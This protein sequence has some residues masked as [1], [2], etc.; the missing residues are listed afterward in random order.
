MLPVTSKMLSAGR[1]RASVLPVCVMF[2]FAAL[3][4]PL[5]SATNTPSTTVLT[6]SPASPQVGG[7]VQTLTATV[8][9]TTGGAS[10][11]PGVVNFY[12]L[13][14]VAAAGPGGGYTARP[15]LIGTAQLLSGGTASI[16][17]ILGG[18]ATHNLHA[19]FLP[20][21]SYATSS[22]TV[23]G[24]VI[25]KNAI[26]PFSVTLTEAANA[27]SLRPSYYMRPQYLYHGLVAPGGAFNYVNTA[28]NAPVTSSNMTLG[29]GGIASSVTIKSSTPVAA[30]PRSVAT[31]DFNGDGKLD[32]VVTNASAATVSVFLGNG[33]GTFGSENTFAVLS[34]GVQSSNGAFSGVATGDFNNDGKVD[35]AVSDGGSGKISILLN[36]SSG[37]TL[38]FASHVD[39]TV[40]A[41][42]TRIV[43]ADFNHDGNLDLAV[44]CN[45]TI[46][47]LL[48]SGSGTF[49]AGTSLSTAGSSDMLVADLN[50]DGAAD[51]MTSN[52]GGNGFDMFLGNGDGTFQGVLRGTPKGA[53][54]PPFGIAVAD[55]NGDGIP[56][57]VYTT[58]GNGHYNMVYYVSGDGTGNFTTSN[59]NISVTYVGGAPGIGGSKQSIA[60]GDVNGDGWPDVVAGETQF[61]EV[62]VLY[63]IPGQAGATSI[64]LNG[65][66]AI[67]ATT[68]NPT[69]FVA[70]DFRGDGLS[71]FAGADSNGNV[72]LFEYNAV[73]QTYVGNT[74]SSQTPGI[75]LTSSSSL[76]A[77][78]F[79]STYV[80][81][82]PDLYAGLLSNTVNIPVYGNSTPALTVANSSY[83]YGQS[84]SLTATLPSI[85]STFP[86][87]TVDINNSGNNTNMGLPQGTL[88]ASG[89]ATVSG[90][91]NS[92]SYSAVAS[93]SGDNTFI[94]DYS[95]TVTFTVVPET[96]TM[97][98]SASPTSQIAG[99]NVTVTGTLGT[100][101]N[102][103][104]G[105]VLMIA[106]GSNS[107]TC[108][109]N[110][111]GVCSVT[112]AMPGAGSQTAMATVA[113]TQNMTT[114]SAT[115]TTTGTTLTSVPS[116]TSSA[117]PSGNGYS[118]TYTASVATQSGVA[119]SGTI[120]FETGSGSVLGG[121]TALSSGVAM[122]TTTP[123]LGNTTVKA[124]YSGNIAY[125]PTTSSTL[126]Q[127]VSVFTS[128]PALTSSA[129]PAFPTQ[130]ITFTATLPVVN[131]FTPT[132]SV[133]FDDGSNTL[134]TFYLNGPSVA[135]F[136]TNALA[137]G[138]HSIVAVYSGDSAFTPQSSS[139]LT[140]VVAA[141][142][143]VASLSA[144]ATV[145]QG[146]PTTLSATVTANGNGVNP[147]LVQFY[148]A[149]SSP[150]LLGTASTNSSGV[151]TLVRVLSPG[152]HVIH[153]VFTGQAAG[154]TGVTSGT[155]TATVTGNG[156]LATM[157]GLNLL[158]VPGGYTLSAPVSLSG[159]STPTG[160]VNFLDATN[161]SAVIG[162]GSVGSFVRTVAPPSLYPLGINPPGI[163]SIASATGD[164]NGDGILD[165]VI[166]NYT[167]GGGGGASSISVLL[168]VG[169][170]TFTTNNTFQAF[171][172]TSLTLVDVDQD[173]I[174]DLLVTR[175]GNN[176]MEVYHGVGDGTFTQLNDVN[177]GTFPIGV[178]V[179]DFDKDGLP[180]LVI[181]NNS[182]GVRYVHGNGDGTFG[183]Y[184]NGTNFTTGN[185]SIGIT[186]GDY[187]R[188]GNPDFIITNAADGTVGVFLGD[189]TG[190]FAP[191][192]TYAVGN[193]PNSIGTGDFNGD[194]KPDIAVTNQSDHTIGILLGNG[195]G[196]F[197]TMVTYNAGSNG[198]GNITIADMN[199]DGKDDL[200]VTNTVT[201]NGS[202]LGI[203]DQNNGGNFYDNVDS[204]NTVGIFTSNGDGTFQ[205]MTTV[206]TGSGTIPYATVVGDFNGDGLPDFAV[207]NSATDNVGVFLG[208][209]AGTATLTGAAVNN[210][211]PV[212][213]TARYTPGS[214]DAYASSISSAV[215]LQGSSVPA[216][217]SS[218]NPSPNG[219]AVTFTA[220]VSTLGGVLPTG[221]II[222]KDGA[223][224]LSTQTLSS[225][226]ASYT[227]SALSTATHIITAVYSGDSHY[228]TT[229][230]APLS[231]VISIP[232]TS[233]TLTTS[234]TPQAYGASLTFAATLGSS[235]ATGT[236]TFKDGVTTL[237]T[238]TLAS[239][240]ATFA[241]SALT[242]GSHSITAVYSGD[243]NYSGNTSASLTQ[244]VSQST[245]ATTTLTTSGT[246][247]AFG[248][249]VTLTATLGNLT[250]TGMV[251]FQDG[252][253]A[254]GI[255]AV[256]AGVAT[257]TSSSL[258]VSTHTITAQYGGDT[259][260]AGT[261]AASLSQVITQGMPVIAAPSVS[262]ASPTYGTSVTIT[263]AVPTGATGLITFYSGATSLGTATVSGGAATLTTTALAGGSNSITTNFPGN[264]NLAAATSAAAN[265]TVTP[266]TL[267][268]SAVTP[269]PTTAVYGTS[270]TLT[271]T[272]PTGATGLVTFF[273]GSTSLGTAT[274]SS[275][276]ATFST[277]ALNV[278]SNNISVSF[279][280]NANYTAAT[281]PT[282]TV[283]ITPLATATTVSVSPSSAPFGSSVTLSATVV[284][285]TGS[286]P[287]PTGLVQFTTGGGAS[288]GSASVNA[289]GVASIALTNLPVGTTAIS[290]TYSAAGNFGASTATN[291]VATITQATPSLT[292]PTLSPTSASYGTLVTITLPV[293]AGATGTMTF[294]AGST[295]LG[296]A[297]IAGGVATLTTTA[298]PVG[299][300]S[301]TVN[302]PG[303]INYTSATSLAA[304]IVV[305]QAT[306]VFTTVTASPTTA[307]YG[308]SVTLS[309]GVTGAA[310]TITFLTGSTSI[311]T[312]TIASG[313]AS[314]TTSTLPVGVNSITVSFAGNANYAAAVSAAAAV[315]ITQTIPTL[316]APTVSPASASYGA[317][318]TLT[319]A[320]PTG[321]TGVITFY[322]GSTSLGT[323]TIT[324]GIATLTTSAL[325]AGTNTITSSYGGN[326]N[327][328]IATSPPGTV[329]ISQATPTLTAP[330]A[331]PTSAS[332]GTPLT[333]TQAV[334]TGVTGNV[335]FYAGSTLLGAATVTGGVATLTTSSIPTGTSA[336]TGV[337]GGN[338]NF[339]AATSAPVMVAISP[340]TT[341]LSL[342]A[343]PL[344]VAYGGTVTLSATVTASGSPLNA[345]VVNFVLGG[346][347]LGTA[348]SNA[349]GLVQL[350]T[351][352]LPVG[353]NSITASLAATAN[354]SASAAPAAIV[355]V[356]QASITLASPSA[357]PTSALYGSSVT[358][359]QTV[360]VGATGSVIFSNGS[361]I[362][363]SATIGNGT[364]TLVTSSLPVGA[365]GI[366]VS[367]AGNANYA[368]TTS[369]ATTVTITA[370]STATALTA[371]PAS[372]T[373]GTSVVLSAAVS[374]GGTPLTSG[375]VQFLNGSVSLGSAAVNGSGVAAFTV[376][377]L[378][379]GTN[380]MTA[381]FLAT[382]N[383]AAS[384]SPSTT[385][386]IT[387]AGPSLGTPSLSPAN[388]VFGTPIT[389]TQTVP[390]GVTGTIIF[391]NGATTIGTATVTGGIATLTTSALP[392]GANAITAGFAGNTN[393][394]AATSTAASITISQA[395]PTLGVPTVSPSNA[396]YGTAVTLTQ[397]VSP[398]A[399]GT[400]TFSNGTVLGAA[401]I[402]NGIATLT[403]SSLPGG[404]NS[405][406]GSYSGN[407]N[408]T[409]ANSTPAGITIN[410]A[411]PTLS[412]PSASPANASIGTPVTLTQ[413]VPTG[414]TGGITFSS[415]TT[416]L[417]TA[418]ISNGVA[419][420]TTSSLPVGINTVIGSYP[421]NANYT[422]GTSSATTVTITASSAT[423]SAPTASPTNAPYGTAVA[424]TQTVP[425]GAT[426]TVI[427]LSG[428][429]AIGTAAIA[430]G[431]ATLTITNL[432]AGTN[433]V[434][435][436]YNGSANYAAATSA[437]T[438]VTITQ[439]TPTL[440]TPGFSPVNASYGT[441][442]T[443]TQ[444]VP[445]SVSGTITFYN[446]SVA[447]GTATIL[448]GVATLTTS[449]LPGGTKSLSASFGGNS[450]Y[451]A[452]TSSPV[453]I[454]ISPATLTL[455]S[456]SASPTSAP[457]GSAV[458]FTQTVPTGA[459]GTVTFYSGSTA[460]GT[461]SIVNSVATF[462][463][464]ALPAG[465]N[466]VTGSFGGN[467]NYTAGTSPATTVTIAPSIPTLSAPSSSPTSATYGASVILTQTV[468]LGATGTVTFLNGATVLGSATI[469]NGV[470]T[471]TT[472]A[473]P[474]GSNSVTGSYSGGGNYTAST[475]APTT[476]TIASN[477]TPG[478]TITANPA[479]LTIHAGSTGTSMLTFLPVG[480]YTGTFTIAC[481]NLPANAA[482]QFL[483]NGVAANT[484]VMTGNNQPVLV[485]LNVITSTVVAES[486]T[487]AKP[488]GTK[489][490][491]I[492]NCGLVA[493]LILGR[494]KKSLRGAITFCGSLFL[495]ALLLG[496]L[497]G[498]AGGGFGVHSTP[499]GTS[500][501]TVTATATTTG[502]GSSPSSPGSSLNLTITIIQ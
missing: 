393:F 12:D 62:F 272:V 134:G 379:V 256:T 252:G 463:T 315:T 87:G 356:T 494:R 395:I 383:Y 414:A 300:N 280:G 34:A 380:T 144:P 418:A 340:G 288:L 160:T 282:A 433:I 4:S 267:A 392:A 230:S 329:T 482:C 168:G 129:N 131:G 161:G 398:G 389:I 181:T 487:P 106:L 188:D 304:S 428:G 431:V 362:V 251:Q 346:V 163:F 98:V 227:T 245:A 297:T 412:S 266:A 89:V 367:F 496:G 221:T 99:Q 341:V 397:T 234:Q 118:V 338:G 298:L 116:L 421:G 37:S 248:T 336:V 485:I 500:V 46:S 442:I 178:G 219:T 109:T 419:S 152:A 192:V 473:L 236:V 402:V 137:L 310:G 455:T 141:A 264:T 165:L 330:S 269:L 296:T 375:S 17:V 198:P 150:Q 490:P 475:S 143:F 495:G 261:T 279:P 49:T 195:D 81:A 209:R 1:S 499:L 311:G 48:G 11:N 420:L 357:S 10:V 352:T 92:G 301:V 201:I 491:L 376:T 305:S 222:F 133:D 127:V 464:T 142:S 318:V 302:F 410:P 423:L 2:L 104:S 365:N 102:S 347:S 468:P 39:Y 177:G 312:A 476:V 277:T 323:G 21:T 241:T 16:K 100:T 238:G 229:T 247:A 77:Q 14:S 225:G 148:D 103:H 386:T 28:T 429:T 120:T 207:P 384:A 390:A 250:A 25:T 205:A 240:V 435:G 197:Q 385:V 53:N 484:I 299:A 68:G 342:S 322:N 460:L 283:T 159:G 449:S 319:Q 286:T 40:A 113:A 413:A 111:S 30:S 88:N 242:A 483:Q 437:P 374:G 71:E 396:S 411:T 440:G 50:N 254:L 73:S 387:Q 226:S 184:G 66:P 35:I 47:L 291:G 258:G 169:D 350:T 95:N 96:P 136:T 228:A 446:G 147:A 6:V 204:D 154:N 80:P 20:T 470:A 416:V 75:F 41:S 408:Y 123:A 425:A 108:T 243:S 54:T 117:N 57:L 151:A 271:Q 268:L 164:L 466:M 477:V 417:G 224:T 202:G 182:T 210:A 203:Q 274:I 441:P 156:T 353:S 220:N 162:T 454:S 114:A 321:V 497:S 459:T 262:P 24:D 72:E 343:A 199:G 358:L 32:M 101:V 218:A 498:C 26:D 361:T 155:Q 488:M 381:S 368:A 465:S 326:T 406:T 469:V 382:G 63:N 422:A 59:S 9:A 65:N 409:A 33:D 223:A 83:N 260:F 328:S 84:P 344:S 501:A 493:L 196:T 208:K 331:S 275:G 394:G 502:S 281:S 166:A 453:S 3:L 426:G 278:G 149:S 167:D 189:G 38:S 157:T 339:T 119:P 424:L 36:T 7:T 191:Q 55:L 360:P 135:T 13:T 5:A 308:A 366:T 23:V 327:Y 293:P 61:D 255:Q 458:T 462:T 448:N 276:V 316:S 257:Y 76:A 290:A 270:I 19:V 461:A 110:S 74:G 200:I 124:V 105:V 93:Y 153:A 443:L 492:V 237:G 52:Y 86:S 333:L 82:T 285:V 349:S 128:V 314:V 27:G 325:P 447:I 434:T 332:F 171:D 284:M 43:L 211:G 401:P 180:D 294:Y 372:G 471:L 313:G 348:T 15:L 444:T 107:S 158:G 213:V 287:L 115:Q 97:A 456:P 45:T 474:V 122:F 190:N 320:V 337:F 404:A 185:S 132:G 472:T 206:S 369:P 430:N 187:N 378:P 303:N 183:N 22:S 403:T 69:S 273:A 8:T 186:V 233:V 170:G 388:A 130:N 172:P 450:N 231:Q 371:S 64:G 56:D 452:A 60:V 457:F 91:L 439:A 317:P 173:G 232:T 44:A 370:L 90:P 140:Q 295:S 432:P 174:L 480:G 31:G 58:Y 263:Q 427:F 391:Y 259:N 85:S 400:V 18:G 306:P 335:S 355:S 307:A 467:G 146:S 486:I 345:G 265:V 179:A 216:L 42:P 481:N 373:Y 194:G 451:S 193:Y 112:L 377:T 217:T 479:S 67:I 309:V 244:V 364:A 249:A 253:A 405:I 121:P 139:A 351:T 215:Q 235:S 78:N 214:S 79:S 176:D 363:G 51:L 334:P 289:S 415:G 125:V 407:T 489:T 29:Q 138:S 212:Q 445:V 478:Y 239:G 94:P 399:T 436:A 70:G 126:T 354:Y 246:P 175:D 324:G 359:T 438:S 145:T 292:A